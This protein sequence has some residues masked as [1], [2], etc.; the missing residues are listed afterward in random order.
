MVCWSSIIDNLMKLVFYTAITKDADRDDILHKVIA[1]FL[2]DPCIDPN[3]VVNGYT[4]LTCILSSATQTGHPDRRFIFGKIA[5]YVLQNYKITDIHHAIYLPPG[6]F[7]E[8]SKEDAIFLAASA[9]FPD[10]VST[11]L[12]LGAH[13]DSYNPSIRETALHAAIRCGKKCAMSPD[14]AQVA[15]LLLK[16]GAN[17][18]SSVMVFLGHFSSPLQDCLDGN[19]D[20]FALVEPIFIKSVVQRARVMEKLREYPHCFKPEAREL[21]SSLAAAAASP[22][23]AAE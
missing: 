10:V 14:H 1:V 18:D 12:D 11:L 19:P 6:I 21:L 9:G 8:K 5:M 20:L 4:F 17:P 23:A 15:E 2:H 22:T 3:T 13:V 16:R 7:S